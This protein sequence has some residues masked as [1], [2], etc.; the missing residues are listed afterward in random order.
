MRTLSAAL[1]LLLAGSALAQGRWSVE[2]YTGTSFKAPT[3][4]E[5]RQEGH[6]DVVIGDVRYETRPF[7]P[8]RSLADL[9]ANDYVLRFGYRL[10]PTRPDIRTALGFEVIHDK[11]HYRSGD[12]PDGVVQDFELS[13]GVSFLLGGGALIVPVATDPDHHDGR[14]QLVARLGVGPVLTKPAATI[15]G[16][17]YGHDTQGQ[18][19]GYDL[20]GIGV[21]R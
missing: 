7:V 13:D 4:L 12:D 21:M 17:S 11:V 9:T 14:G 3:T 2:L 15:R 6:D 1:T 8:L 20:A 16:R 19:T 5:I 18:W 10:P